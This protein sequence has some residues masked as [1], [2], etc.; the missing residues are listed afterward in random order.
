MDHSFLLRAERLLDRSAAAPAID[1]SLLVA[2][3]TAHQAATATARAAAR[4][5]GSPAWER[6]SDAL[7]ELLVG[8][9]AWRA[10]RRAQRGSFHRPPIASGNGS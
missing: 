6:P 5:A 4:A 3:L 9:P 7:V 8:G 2:V 10:A 1:H